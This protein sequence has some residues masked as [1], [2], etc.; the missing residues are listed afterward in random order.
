MKNG[1]SRKLGSQLVRT[2]VLFLDLTDSQNRFRSLYIVAENV[3]AKLLW[4][5]MKGT[6]ALRS[7]PFTR[8]P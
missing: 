4:G 2:L 5:P 6:R 8:S 3:I 1:G 7:G